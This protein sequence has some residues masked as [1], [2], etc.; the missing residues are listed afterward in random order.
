MRLR[1]LL[2]DKIITHSVQ[3]PYFQES[4]FK[5]GGYMEIHRQIHG[6]IDFYNVLFYNQGSKTYDTHQLL[7][8]KSDP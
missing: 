4:D 6:F 7:F 2:P 5:N 1:Q 8:Q 3:A